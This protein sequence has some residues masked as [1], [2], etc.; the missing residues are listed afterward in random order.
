LV[1]SPTGQ[2]EETLRQVLGE[3]AITT[4]ADH[5]IAAGNLSQQLEEH[6]ITT[7]A[8]LFIAAGNL[9]Q[10]MDDGNAQ[11]LKTLERTIQTIVDGNEEG[12]SRDSKTR[13]LLIRLTTEHSCLSQQIVNGNAQILET[14][15]KTMQT[16][17]NGKEDDASRDNTIRKL[18]SE[19]S[20]TATAMLSEIYKM[21]E[22]ISATLKPDGIP[23]PPV[24]PSFPSF[25]QSC[26]SR[27]P[28]TG[29]S[30]SG[31]FTC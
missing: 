6:G 7:A 19:H 16:I 31:R 11:I 22:E 17:I 24:V 5:F 27:C 18:L 29:I 30:G 3:H 15:K 20:F 23:L 12:A 14:L 21:R 4:A 28:F 9:S 25:F 10:Q 2:F 13:E 1:S 26:S 8:D